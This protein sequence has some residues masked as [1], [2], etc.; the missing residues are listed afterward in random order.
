MSEARMPGN[1]H[2]EA[3]LKLGDI[4]VERALVMATL[5][6]AHEQRTANLIACSQKVYIRDS[7]DAIRE[8]LGEKALGV[9]A[10]T[11]DEHAVDME[12]RMVAALHKALSPICYTKPYDVDDTPGD[13]TDYG[14]DGVVNLQQIA[15]RVLDSIAESNGG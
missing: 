9:E 12:A 6:L 4:P 11:P 14:V 10:P 13:I 3:M 5:A 2:I 1:P 15:A 8:R 7:P